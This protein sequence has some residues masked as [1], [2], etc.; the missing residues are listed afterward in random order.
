MTRFGQ[1]TLGDQPL[2]DPQVASV[3]NTQSRGLGHGLPL[4]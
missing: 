1:V 3:K 4:H 2:R